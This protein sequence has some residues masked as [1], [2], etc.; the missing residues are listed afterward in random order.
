MK[1]YLA[2]I[3]V[4]V[5]VAYCLAQKSPIIVAPDGTYLGKLN[6]NPYDPDSVS[7]PYGRYGSPYSRNS[8]NNPYGKY[9]NPYGA[10]SPFPWATPIAPAMPPL[11]RALPALEIRPV[12]MPDILDSMMQ[13]Q[14]LRNAQQE[15]ELREE[16]LR[17][18]RIENQ[19][20]ATAAKRLVE[21]VLGEWELVGVE[22]PV[23][24]PSPPTWQGLSPDDI[25]SLSWRPASVS[26][27]AAAH[28]LTSGVTRASTCAYWN[29]MPRSSRSAFF[30]GLRDGMIEA[31][32]NLTFLDRSTKAIPMAG[33]YFSDKHLGDVGSA[34]DVFCAVPRN[35]AIP[36]VSAVMIAGMAFNDVDPVV[37]QRKL[38]E[39]RAAYPVAAAP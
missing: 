39:L 21:P 28:T 11:V 20:R 34:L 9:G 38:D 12:P 33:L 10:F 4:L 26:P 5:C 1:I 6:T 14:N 23:P 17:R 18:T 15:Y 27:P 3:L 16:E 19:A 29:L 31:S 22:T 25:G 8:I 37:L 2:I 32:I 24:V 35:A 30:L 7:N 13:V 36:I